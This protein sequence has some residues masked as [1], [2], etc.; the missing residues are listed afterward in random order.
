MWIGTSLR[1]RSRLLL[2]SP[3]PRRVFG[4]HGCRR[5]LDFVQ[6][7]LGVLRR[8]FQKTFLAAQSDWPRASPGDDICRRAGGPSGQ[9]QHFVR[10]FSARGREPALAGRLRASGRVMQFSIWTDPGNQELLT[11]QEKHIPRKKRTSIH[12]LTI[13]HRMV[14]GRGVVYLAAAGGMY[15]NMQWRRERHARPKQY[16]SPQKPPTVLMPTRKG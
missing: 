13:H 4:K 7:L 5:L 10:P 9:V 8:D 12:H 16:H 1:N 11:H 15:N 6:P 2:P 14:P 3:Q